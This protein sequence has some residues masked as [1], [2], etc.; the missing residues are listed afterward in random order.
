MKWIEGLWRYSFLTK[1]AK[2]K[3]VRSLFF[4]STCYSFLTKS[5]KLKLV[6]YKGRG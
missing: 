4:V 5:A 6:R 3:Q 1:S 2:L